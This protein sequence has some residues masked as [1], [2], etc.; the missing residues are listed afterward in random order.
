MQNLIWQRTLAV[1][2]VAATIALTAPL[3]AAIYK[4]VDEEGNIVYTDV[5]P[6]KD[7]KAVEVVPRNTYQTPTQ[8]A[9]DLWSPEQDLPDPASA[10]PA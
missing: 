7:A 10:A 6:N 5:K 1:A 3:Q 9:D 8:P 4:T 2:L